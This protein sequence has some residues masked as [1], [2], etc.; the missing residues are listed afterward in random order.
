MPAQFDATGAFRV[1]S[2]LTVGAKKLDQAGARATSSLARGL[3]PQATRDI[4]DEFN[5]T[6]ARIRQGLSVRRS[7]D[8]V[9]L[10]GS[11]AGIG[12]AQGYGGVQTP[13]GV[14]VTLKRREGAI[15]LRHAFLAKPGGK[16]K[17][18]GVQ[19]FQRRGRRAPRYPIDRL[20]SQNIAG[21][22]RSPARRDRLVGF[23]MNVLTAEVRRQLGIP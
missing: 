23:G 3:V 16:T 11:G 5:L 14:L 12:I 18:T 4:A 22:L 9:D 21:T 8:Y 19:A 17:R 6:P 1:A 13:R 2:R 15:R 10:V 20:F 7:A